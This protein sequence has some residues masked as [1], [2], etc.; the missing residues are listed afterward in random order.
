MCLNLPT[1]HKY[2]TL[3]DIVILIGERQMDGLATVYLPFVMSA[4]S[5]RRSACQSAL[6]TVFFDW[7]DEHEGKFLGLNDI[8]KCLKRNVKPEEEIWHWYWT[9]LLPHSAGVKYWNETKHL[10]CTIVES[11][12]KEAPDAPSSVTA[13]SEGFVAV[14]WDNCV[15]KWTNEYNLK[16]VN[17]KARINLKL[18][19]FKGKY[20]R[21]DTG[22]TKFG[23][24]TSQGLFKYQEY[25]KLAKHGRA[26]PGTLELEKATLAILQKANNIDLSVKPSSGKKRRRSV[27]DQAPAIEIDFDDED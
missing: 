18:D 21:N 10:Y 7:A 8:L 4:V 12:I 11:K 13:A 2:L 17:P 14:I 5:D 1:V 16:K 19:E 22:Q 3:L 26:Q 23:G 15:D 27:A 20:T 25:V 24:W 6:K 9:R